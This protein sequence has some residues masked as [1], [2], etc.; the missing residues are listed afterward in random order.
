VHKE[1]RAEI[2]KVKAAYDR[3]KSSGQLTREEL[4]QAFL[5]SRETIAQIEGQSNAWGT[6]LLRAKGQL[7]TMAVS[8]AS[9]AIASR[10]VRLR[11][12]NG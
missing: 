3:L 11:I 10:A 4:V 7:A 9:F 2:E 6:S 5:R 8:F 12:G 1:V